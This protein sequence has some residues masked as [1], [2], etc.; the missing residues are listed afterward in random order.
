MLLPRHS[1]SSLSVHVISLLSFSFTHTPT[2][3]AHCKILLPIRLLFPI[4][5]SYQHTFLSILPHKISL[6]IFYSLPSNNTN[7][8]VCIQHI[9]CRPFA[10]NLLLIYCRPL[11]LIQFICH[12][13]DF[14]NVASKINPPLPLLF[15][16]HFLF[17]L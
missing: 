3:F 9:I 11:S 15:A 17:S 10:P 8:I 12:F 7:Q 14:A 4:P 1:F 13:I 2:T 5:L 6:D 16:P